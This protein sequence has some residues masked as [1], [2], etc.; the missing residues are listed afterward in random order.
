MLIK[1]KAAILVSLEECITYGLNLKYLWNKINWQVGTIR[2][3]SK[4]ELWHI[5]ITLEKPQVYLLTCVSKIY[6]YMNFDWIQSRS[7]LFGKQVV[8][9]SKPS[10]KLRYTYLIII[11]SHVWFVYIIHLK[12]PWNVS[13]DSGSFI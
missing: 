6:C 8:G 5:H 7:I 11:I 3:T 4:K 2:K 12:Y 9:I 1:M 10:T 13:K